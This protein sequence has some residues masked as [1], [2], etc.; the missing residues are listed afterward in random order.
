MKRYKLT[1]EEE[2]NAELVL[3]HTAFEKYCG[4]C[5]NFNTEKCPRYG[6]VDEQTNWKT[7][8]CDKFWD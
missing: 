4:A 1:P 8:G 3:D 7:I 6:K 2:I 5:D